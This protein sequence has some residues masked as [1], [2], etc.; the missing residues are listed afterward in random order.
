MDITKGIK[1]I[2]KAIVSSLIP[3]MAPNKL[4]ISIMSVSTMLLT[5]IF[6]RNVYLSNFI[7]FLVIVFIPTSKDLVAFIIQKA[8]PMSKMNMIIS[9][10]WLNP[11]ANDVKMLQ[12]CG[13]SST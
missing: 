13:D 6:C 4:K 7:R 8:P 3:K 11:L 9:D 10:C 5:P 12:N 1:I 2:M